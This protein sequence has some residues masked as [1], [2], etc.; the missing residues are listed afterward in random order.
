MSQHTHL[1]EHARQH[2]APTRINAKLVT[3]LS[4]A[5]ITVWHILQR[6]AWYKTL[7]HLQKLDRLLAR[8]TLTKLTKEARKGFD[9]QTN[10]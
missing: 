6:P 8:T 3:V 10:L 9:A 7:H 5:R 1:Y 4:M 2:P